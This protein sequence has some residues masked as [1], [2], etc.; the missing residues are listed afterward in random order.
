MRQ[1]GGLRWNYLVTEVL[2]QLSILL[3]HL[4]LVARVSGLEKYCLE[5][6]CWMKTLH[7]CCYTC[8]G[9]FWQYA[10]NFSLQQ[11]FFVDL[12]DC[13]MVNLKYFLEKFFNKTTFIMFTF[14][15]EWEVFVHCWLGVHLEKKI[16][17]FF[18]SDHKMLTCLIHREYIKFIK[19]T[20]SKLN[21]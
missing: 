4:D 13:W 19:A 6:L 2:L 11:I 18:R 7:R 10:E 5:Q 17:N 3:E 9:T 1:S 14:Q 12:L 21:V 20:R 8:S 15:N 16:K